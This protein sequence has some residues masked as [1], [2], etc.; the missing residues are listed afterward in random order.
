MRP[1]RQHRM[2]G[3]VPLTIYGDVRHGDLEIDTGRGLVYAVREDHRGG[4]E[5]VGDIVT[6][7]ERVA[8]LI[9]EISEAT[10]EQANGIEEMSQTVAHM[11]E[12]TQ[13]N[14]ALAEQSAASAA[15]L[16][17]RPRRSVARVRRSPAAT[18]SSSCGRG[19]TASPSSIPTS[20]GSTGWSSPARSRP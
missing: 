3:L 10:A 1:A 13:A 19:A 18:P 12:M 6:Q 14:A 2:R 15:S 4:G 20:K 11:D 9:S 16:A 8:R 5:A 7:V 17:N